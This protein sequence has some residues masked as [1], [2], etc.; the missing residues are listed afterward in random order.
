MSIPISQIIPP[1]PSPPTPT[2]PLGVHTFILYICVSTSAL[3]TGSSEPFFYTAHIC[4][5]IWYLF[6][7]FWLTSLCMTVSR[8]IHISIN[9]R[10]SFLFMAELYSIVYMCHIF[11]IHPSVNGHLGCF[12]VLAIVNSAAMNIVVHDSFWIMVL[13]GYMPSSGIAESYGSSILVF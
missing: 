11:F 4:I 13:S 3:Q 12:Y 10:I 2:Y 1:R 5:N 6:F 7:S 9:G 8:S